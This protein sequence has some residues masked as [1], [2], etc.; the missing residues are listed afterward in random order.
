MNLLE[1]LNSR[2]EARDH[3]RFCHAPF[4]SL[5]FGLKGNVMTCCYNKVH[6]LGNI[7][8]QSIREIWEG[9]KAQQIRA[10]LNLNELKY[11]CQN[12]S[13]IL[14]SG[15]FESSPTRVYD[16]LEEHTR[17]PSRMEFEL[18][19]TCNL[20]CIMCNGESSSAIRERR[21]RR[22]PI[23]SPYGKD[24][25]GQLDEFI[26][27]LQNCTFLGGEPFLIPVYFEIW[28]RMAAINPAIEIS[29]QTNGTILNSRVKKI[30]E[31]LNFNITISLDSVV[32]E[33]YSAIRVNSTLSR[34]K[35][36]IAYFAEYCK[37]RNKG[38]SI[39]FCVMPQNRFEL[40]DI[41]QFC[42]QVGAHVFFN[43]VFFPP[44]CSLMNLSATEKEE[45]VVFMESHKPKAET[46]LEKGN[47]NKYLD[48]IAQIKSWINTNTASLN[49][50]PLY[51]SLTDLKE[52]LKLFLNDSHASS[53]RFESIT[54]KLDE[55][56]VLATNDGY[57]HEAEAALLRVNPETFLR[58]F[59]DITAQRGYELLKEQVLKVS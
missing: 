11:G 19:N 5:F 7:Q 32:D 14:E 13:L 30:L 20:E 57:K 35:E 39:S 12:C 26:P 53:N 44:E 16:K 21:E 15:N 24:F 28:E 51:Q 43:T 50:E 54:E 45:V 33:T 59:P 6:I 23:L 31:S 3:A 49:T 17:Y 52:Q 18:D 38:M 9:E 58:F 42:N 25:I 48:V 55:I 37:A 4:R 46:T 10:S 1:Q 22:P 40:H 47:L 36:N 29:I 8:Q 2:R 34:V 56:I 27:H 41:V